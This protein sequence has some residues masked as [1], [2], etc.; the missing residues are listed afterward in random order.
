MAYISCY[1]H[2]YTINAFCYTQKA[3]I[4]QL[5]IYVNHHHLGL[6]FWAAL[7]GDIGKKFGGMAAIYKYMHKNYIYA[8]KLYMHKQ[9]PNL[10]LSNI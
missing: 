6:G 4:M 8:Q 7:G 5:H 9:I 3:P 10:Y 1:N 2:S